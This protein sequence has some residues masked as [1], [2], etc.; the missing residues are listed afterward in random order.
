MHKSRNWILGLA[1][2]LVALAIIALVTFN[3]VSGPS[4]AVAQAAPA[5]PTATASSGTHKPD[6]AKIQANLGEFNSI[7]GDFRKNLAGRLNISEDQLQTAIS[8][9]VSDTTAQMVKDGKL[10]QSQ[11]DHLNALSAEF[12]KG[13][14]FPPDA[15]VISQVA[16][17][18]PLSLD[19]FK[20]IENDVAASLKL[21]TS[22]LE[23]Q[24][25]AGKSLT[26]IAAAQNVDIQTVKDTLLKSLKTQL[27]AAVKAGKLTQ[28]QEDQINQHASQ[29]V[30]KLVT[31]TPGSFKK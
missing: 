23:T 17:L 25:K 2:G 27:D 16:G 1:G 5:T 10:T 6:L 13:V 28:T 4:T 22:E 21:Q 15:N 30:D 8:G 18:V 31:L 20:Q 19:Q 11:A 26:D 3:L 29:F 9:A 12:S 14:T 7:L 24:I